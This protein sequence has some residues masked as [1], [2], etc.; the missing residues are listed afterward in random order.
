MLSRSL[1]A[2]PLRAAS[3]PLSS[4]STTPWSHI[5]KRTKVSVAPAVVWPKRKGPRTY[6]ERKT[7]KVAEYVRLFESSKSSPLIF[8]EHNDFSVQ[9]LSKLRRDIEKAAARHITPAPSLSTLS[10]APT[11]EPPALP[12]FTVVS[13]SYFGVALRNYAPL[14]GDTIKGIAGLQKNG[15]AVLSFPDFNP[16]Q[17]D[18]VIR[19]MARSVPPRKA[20]TS[21]ELAQEAKDAVDA[22]VPGRR[23]KRQRPEPVPDL[24]VAGALI[25]GR[26]FKAAEVTEVAK[27]PTL[28]T[29]RAQLVGL[30]SAP[31]SQLAAL[32]NEAGGAKLAR[33]L[34]GLKKSLEE[35]ED[36]ASSS[37]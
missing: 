30:L 26:V 3:S 22:Y 9:R 11:T 15:L 5:I 13:T 36:G 17:L 23:L 10:P 37:A 27:L 21:E 4:S 32:L 1:L 35:K 20:K 28:D 14:D 2:P 12:K 6:S 33:T 7:F 31:S 18:A 16:P 19:A 29:L 25:E 34:E 8:L 24:K